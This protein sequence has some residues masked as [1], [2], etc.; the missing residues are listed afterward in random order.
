MRESNVQKKAARSASLTPV[1][2]RTVDH[3]GEGGSF[4]FH[5]FLF[6]RNVNLLDEIEEATRKWKR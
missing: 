5:P 3:Y 4:Y 2:E 1:R 6:S